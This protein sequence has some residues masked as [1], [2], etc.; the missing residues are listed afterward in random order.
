MN[1][2]LKTPTYR[3]LL[4]D[5]EVYYNYFCVG[6]KDYETK[7]I[8]FY[9]VSNVKD[10][11]KHIYD[12]FSDYSEFLISFN[13]ISY[14]NTIIKY[15]L[16]LY[17]TNQCINVETTC[18]LLKLFSDRVINDDFNDQ[19]VRKFKYL[20]SKWIDIDLFAYWSKMLR[21]SKK[22]SLKSLGIQLGYPVVQELPYSPDT[23]L[24]DEDLPKLR[25]YNYT[26]DLGILEMLVT[27]MN[28]DIQLRSNVVKD[29]NLDCWSW[30]AIKIASEALLKNYCE[31]TGASVYEMRKSRFE[32]NPLIIS[33]ILKDFEPHFEL[34][35]FKN[36]Y[37]E[38][39]SSIDTFSK[40][41]LVTINNTNIRLSYGVGGLHSI[42]ENES[43]YSNDDYQVVTSDVT[44]LYPN[45]II[46]Y[47]CIRFP[48][49]LKRYA[50]IKEERVIAKRNG[51][52]PKDVF[53]KLILNGTSGLLDNPHGW[54]YY[55]EGALRLRLIG[56]LIITKCIEVC[57]QNNWQV[58]SVNTD[59]IEC[60]VP[61]NE[62]NS[63]FD[64][65]DK[66]ISLFNIQLEHEK[67][68]KIVYKNV[69]N[70]IA[71]TEHGKIKQKGLFVT[72]P[73][74]GN[75]TDTLV[76]A[77]ALNA[78]YVNQIS[79]EEFINNPDKYNLHI[80]DYCKSNK[81]DKSFYVWWNDEIQQQLNRYYFKKGNPYLLK[82]RKHSKYT[83]KDLPELTIQI[84]KDSYGSL[85]EEQAKVLAENMIF[86]SQKQHV[87]VGQGVELFNTYIDKPF[88]EY[89]I[90]YQY[91]ISQVYKII[92]EINNYNQLTLF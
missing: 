63:Y 80:Y 44:S 84:L 10:D 36:L 3:K 24:T 74:L 61:Q 78:Y 5:I 71:I 50:E 38:I 39:L 20:K 26:H 6:L 32:K 45:L 12:F 30:D 86:S 75:S 8:I 52:K 15:F 68:N 55:P 57:I 40:E 92:N 43:Y 58:V 81:I 72:D 37:K 51:D 82:S 59:G 17:E 2:L 66:T 70:Y 65:L 87:N 21:I 60:I 22:I 41:L 35:I 16:Y 47:N 85:N 48:E 83:I 19:E 79:P 14:D 91:Y 28:D 53:F 76:V 31:S 73:V 67:Y 27:K 13:G 90:D 88:E 62:L 25:Y 34:P 18:Y 29:F 54:L 11:T 1:K 49:V 9:E 42:N 7:E 77:K 33:E 89:D 46:N 64:T 69:N 56:Q 23:I 4:Y